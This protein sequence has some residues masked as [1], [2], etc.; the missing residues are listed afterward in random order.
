MKTQYFTLP[1]LQMAAA[2]FFASTAQAQ[3]SSN[4]VS[5]VDKQNVRVE[6]INCDGTQNGGSFFLVKSKAPQPAIG[7][8]VTELTA[9]PVDSAAPA[10]R[11]A[12]GFPESGLVEG[13]F[14]RRGFKRQDCNDDPNC[15]PN[16]DNCCSSGSNGG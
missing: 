1:A 12:A 16:T 10:S 11:K 14:G 6:D 2:T 5:C 4:T 8:V 13:G 9:G 3:E 15:D 7:Q